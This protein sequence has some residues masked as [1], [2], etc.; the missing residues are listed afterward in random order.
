MHEEAVPTCGVSLILLS[1]ESLAPEH[2][3]NGVEV[4]LPAQFCP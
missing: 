1:A 2:A 3:S 4:T